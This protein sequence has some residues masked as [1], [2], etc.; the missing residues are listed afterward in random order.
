MRADGHQ[1]FDEVGLAGGCA[2]FAAPAAALGAIERERCALDIAAVRDGDQHVFVDDQIFD[3]KIAFGLD[4]LGAARV[5][6]FLFDVFDFE[7]ISAHHLAFI[8]EH[9]GEPRDGVLGFLV[10]GA[11]L[12]RSSEVSRREREI[13]DRLGLKLGERELAHQTGARGLGIFRRANQLDHR[14]EVL[15]RDQQAVEDVQARLGLALFVLRAPR[16]HLAPIEQERVR[17]S[18]AG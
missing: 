12:S 15:E 18:R 8:V 1:V 6:E 14:V 2:D 17:A 4:D 9:L 10:L 7:A 13:E 16:Q 11:I 3:R 5:A